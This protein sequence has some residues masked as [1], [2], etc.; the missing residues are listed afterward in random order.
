MER[1]LSTGEGETFRGLLLANFEG[2]RCGE[3]LFAESQ[4]RA[5]LGSR[6]KRCASRRDSGHRVRSPPL[7]DHVHCDSAGHLRGKLRKITPSSD[8]SRD[9]PGGLASMQE[10]R[11][12]PS[13]TYQTI[14]PSGTEYDRHATRTYG[15]RWFT[16]SQDLRVIV[17]MK[18]QAQTMSI[19]GSTVRR[20]NTE[21]MKRGL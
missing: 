6:S 5:G 16:G 13:E 1:Y 19:S 12:K 9:L 7:R 15:V 8:T 20:S 3:R 2:M 11:P 10:I 4:A 17:E 18:G 14:G 21:A